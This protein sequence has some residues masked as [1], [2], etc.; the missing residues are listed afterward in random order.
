MPVDG[1]RE[2]RAARDWRALRPQRGMALLAQ[3][4]EGRG[5]LE[6]PLFLLA[7]GAHCAQC[8]VLSFCCAQQE[9][10]R[11]ME[12][13]RSPRG[14]PGSSASSVRKRYVPEDAGSCLRQ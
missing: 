14:C 12:D 10:N 2:A 4:V 1:E 11:T 7:T 13:A 5:V 6:N 8:N 3:R 9:A